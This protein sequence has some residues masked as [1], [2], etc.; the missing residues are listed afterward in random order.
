MRMGQGAVIRDGFVKSQDLWTYI[1]DMTRY[2]A[3]SSDLMPLF[4]PPFRQS[5]SLVLTIS[6]NVKITT[7]YLWMPLQ[8]SDIMHA[9]LSSLDYN[10]S[11]ISSLSLL[12][13][14]P[15]LA[16]YTT[17]L[18]CYWTLYSF[19]FLPD[20]QTQPTHPFITPLAFTIPKKIITHLFAFFISGFSISSHPFHSIFSPLP[21]PLL[22]RVLFLEFSSGTQ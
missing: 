19:V 7:T 8:Q 5:L 3:L 17:A 22:A 4:F 6:R 1:D 2:D 14:F 20:R 10:L 16:T 13:S 11:V 12:F 18:P 15:S 9:P 21:L